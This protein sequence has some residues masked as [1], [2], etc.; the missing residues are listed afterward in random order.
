M[1]WNFSILVSRLQA[2][3]AC[4]LSRSF[5][6]FFQPR[7]MGGW[8]VHLLVEDRGEAF[9]LLRWCFHVFSHLRLSLHPP[10]KRIEYIKSLFGFPL[11]ESFKEIS[12]KTTQQKNMNNSFRSL[13]ACIFPTPQLTTLQLPCPSISFHG[14]GNR[15]GLQPCFIQVTTRKARSGWLGSPSLSEGDEMN[16]RKAQATGK[17]EWVER[18]Q[19]KRRLGWWKILML[20]LWSK[21]TLVSWFFFGGRWKKS[22]Q[23]YRDYR[24]L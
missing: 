11:Q 8:R 17:V 21:Y 20:E 1:R 6:V 15:R 10:A 23:L 7:K 9:R 14:L 19:A 24:L 16:G 5:R 12:L 22:I 4:C 2:L 18:C 3:W 13:V